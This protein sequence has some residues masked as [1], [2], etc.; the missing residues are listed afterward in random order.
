MV[1]EARIVFNKSRVGIHAAVVAGSVL[2]CGVLPEASADVG[3]QLRAS[4]IGRAHV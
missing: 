3:V 2:V 4:K 1:R